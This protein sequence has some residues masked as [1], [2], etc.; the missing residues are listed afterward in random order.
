VCLYRKERERD[1]ECDNSL[2]RGLI[3][4]LGEAS[5]AAPTRVGPFFD[6]ERKL[7][8]GLA[9]WFLWCSARVRAWFPRGRFRAAGGTYGDP[10]KDL[11]NYA[12]TTAGNAR[13][14]SFSI[15]E[16]ENVVH[17]GTRVVS[18]EEAAKLT[19]GV[20]R[21]VKLAPCTNTRLFPSPRPAKF[22]IP[23]RF[24]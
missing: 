24:H 1:R 17:Q 3:A 15:D 9:R 21:T 20:T 10:L 12:S 14:G 18:E 4:A 19:S 5:T 6:E 16:D 7:H 11:D 13:L 22:G 8:G 23:G 2:W